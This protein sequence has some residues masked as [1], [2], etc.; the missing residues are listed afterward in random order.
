LPAIVKEYHNMSD[1]E[2]WIKWDSF[3]VGYIYG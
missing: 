1:K 2:K 3:L